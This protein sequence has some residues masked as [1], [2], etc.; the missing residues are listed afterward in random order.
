MVNFLP[1]PYPDE[2]FYSLLTRCHMRSA[3]K[4]LR[5]TL[6]GLL[7]Y[8]SKK[9]FRQDLPDGLSNLMM[10]LPPASPHFVED[11][12]QNH[13]LYPFYKSFLTPSEAWLLKHRMIKAT[14]ESFISLAKLS[15]DGLDSNRKFLQF[16][17]ACLEEEEARYGEAYWHRMHQAPGVFVCS[18][19]KVPLQ[20][21]LIPLHNI[22]REYVPANTYNCPN[23]RSKNRYSEVALQT[24]LT[25]YDDI[26]W[27][28]YSAPS[29]KGLKWLRKRY[30]T[31]LTQQ[32]Y[33]ST[34][35]KSKSDFNSQTLFEDITNFYGL[36]VLDLI[37]PDK[38][39]NMKVYLEC[40]LLAC[41]IDQVIDR[42]THLLL[43]KF[44]SGSLE[45]F[46]N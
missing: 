7:G 10:S 20:D 33:V 46:F 3:D 28:M 12:I 35:P 16:C 34:L 2:H 1:H 23:N 32:D 42:I 36:E 18:N 45:H 17:P 30:Q 38:V 4:K 24:L 39:A 14:N 8:S 11:L 25:L 43:I 21:S 5:K 9:L 19:H 22:D 31:F 29:F 27:L 26:E 6:K 44:L 37:K 41:D 15:P 40:C 13:T